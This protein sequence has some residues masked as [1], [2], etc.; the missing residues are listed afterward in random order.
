MS[1]RP[2]ASSRAVAARMSRQARKDTAP[3]LAVRRSLHAAGLRYRVS[4]GVPGL[5]RCTIDI[6]F[7]RAKVAV[8]IDG[9]FWHSCPEHATVPQ[10]NQDWW[11][12]KLAA[13]RERDT[14]VTAHL[15]T[16]G[17]VVLRVWE[18]EDPQVARLRVVSQ[19]QVTATAIT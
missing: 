8:F 17:W 3:E 13:N 19:L 16:L 15:V 14:R 5:A 11:R 6:A 2:G 4:Y 10:A 9:C 18:H 12:A 7:T 1:L